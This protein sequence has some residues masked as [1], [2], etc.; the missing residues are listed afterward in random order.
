MAQIQ[1][2]S[3]GSQP[4]FATDTLNG[5]QLSANVAYAPA[6]VPTNFAGPKLDFFG[7]TLGGGDAAST[8][9]GVNGAVQ[10]L[11]QTIQ[12][13]SVVAM[14]QVDA[15]AST[16]NFSVATFPTGAFNTAQDGTD[17]S[18]TTLAALVSGI[19]TVNGYNFAGTT[20]T[21]VGFRLASTATAP[22]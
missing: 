18:T 8:Q 7:M 10:T 5:P 14:Y 20:V 4:V 9:A 12:Q 16:N 2:V 15:T 22:C 1:I 11:L 19:G 13:Y 6:G 21:N 3:G 17:N